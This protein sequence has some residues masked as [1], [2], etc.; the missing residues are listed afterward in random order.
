MSKFDVGDRVR[1]MFED[2]MYNAWVFPKV[3][4]VVDVETAPEEPDF[5]RVWWDGTDIARV[6]PTAYRADQLIEE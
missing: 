2:K 1:F 6:A 4:T 3:G 5:Y